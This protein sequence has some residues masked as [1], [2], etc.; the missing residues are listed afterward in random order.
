MRGIGQAHPQRFEVTDPAGVTITAPTIDRGIPGQRF[1]PLQLKEFFRQA[2]IDMVPGEDFNF[3]TGAQIPARLNA[4]ISERLLPFGKVKMLAPAVKATTE[5]R[6]P[7]Q[8]I[9][10]APV[11]TGETPSRND[12]FAS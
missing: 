4:A 1:L 6:R 11:A 5:L 10:Q 12:N 3:T 8:N 9:G 7:L 2:T